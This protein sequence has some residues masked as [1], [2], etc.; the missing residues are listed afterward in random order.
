LRK[1]KSRRQDIKRK[2]DREC[3]KYRREGGP[4]QRKREG[5]GTGR[6]M[7]RDHERNIQR[8]WKYFPPLQVFLSL[9]LAFRSPVRRALRSMSKGAQLL[10]PHF[11]K[12]REGEKQNLNSL[13]SP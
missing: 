8:A 1:N 5:G 3:T 4:T 7:A 6:H 2:K 12:E 10:S 13:Q 11:S 9:S